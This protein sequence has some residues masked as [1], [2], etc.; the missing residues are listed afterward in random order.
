MPKT[1]EVEFMIFF[2]TYL[3]TLKKEF[4]ELLTEPWLRAGLMLIN[5]S[6]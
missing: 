2:S 4:R 5:V 1:R 3:T 6:H